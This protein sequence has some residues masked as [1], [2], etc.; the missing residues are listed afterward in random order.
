[1]RRILL[2][3][4][5]VVFLCGVAIP[6]NDKPA[7][8]TAL[9][10]RQSVYSSATIWDWQ[11]PDNDNAILDRCGYRPLELNPRN[12]LTEGLNPYVV[13]CVIE[14]ML[15]TN[16]SPEAVR[17][18]ETMTLFLTDF[19]EQ[20][21]VDVGRAAAPWFNMGRGDMVVLNGNPSAILI[22]DVVSPDWSGA[23][24]YHPYR[25]ALHWPE[26]ATLTRS[27]RLPDGRQQLILHVPIQD[28]RACPALALLRLLL[29]FSLD[30]TLIQNTVLSPPLF[31]PTVLV[32]EPREA[33][34]L[35]FLCYWEGCLRDYAVVIN[36]DQLPLDLSWLTIIRSSDRAIYY[37]FSLLTSLN[38]GQYVVVQNGAP[39]EPG[40]GGCVPYPH[41]PCALPTEFEPAEVLRPAD[42]LLVARD[43]RVLASASWPP[44][45]SGLANPSQAAPM[46]SNLPGLEESACLTRPEFPP[47]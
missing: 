39:C 9:Q 24:G 8:A 35:L 32:Q 23:P 42:F 37:T 15:R 16:A 46:P 4:P 1:M 40:P 45:W 44:P 43:G 41:A 47:N 6:T 18:F 14:A 19:E 33:L 30:G 34:Q 2:V 13:G 5:I 27:E 11:A 21:T 28:C 22:R 20:G 26:Y 12:P 3:V 25:T 36:R 29:T 17:F 38:P 10:G 31:G 7:R